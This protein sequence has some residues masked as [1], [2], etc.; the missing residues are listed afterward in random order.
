MLKWGRLWLLL[1]LGACSSE[2]Y[3]AHN[4]S[5]SFDNLSPISSRQVQREQQLVL[6][7]HYHIEVA[8]AS[9]GMASE[10]VPDLNRLARDSLARQLRRY[11]SHV[12]ISTEPDTLQRSLANASSEA[13]VLIFPRI[14]SWP[15]IKPIRIQ[16]CETQAGEKKTS[17]G[18]CEADDQE[19]SD[20]IVVTIGL[21]DVLTGKHLDAI[22]ARSRRGVA[23]YLF[24]QNEEEL[25]ELNL[26]VVQR[27]TSHAGFR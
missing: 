8:F 23:S 18:E 27:L 26:M 5:E 16:E 6:S 14:E 15:N 1:I 25:D 11:F 20:E 10:D 19:D 7:P 9:G 24:G 4:S 12:T 17:L 3:I 21:Y 2:S 22:H 13:Q